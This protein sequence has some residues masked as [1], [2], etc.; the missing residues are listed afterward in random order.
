MKFVQDN[1]ARSTYGVIRGLHFQLD[2]TGTNQIDP[3]FKRRYT[4]CGSGC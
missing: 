4:G 2:P 1:Q 3:C